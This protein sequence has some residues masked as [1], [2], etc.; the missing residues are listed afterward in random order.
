MIT[1]RQIERYWMAK[2]Y[3]RLYREL[4]AARP[5]AGFRLEVDVRAPLAAAM[6]IIRLDELAQ[7]HVPLYSRLLR[8]ILTSQEA[9]GGWGA[10]VTTALCVRALLCGS[11]NGYAVDLGIEYLANLQKTEGI[12]PN[13]PLRRM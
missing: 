7:S 1:V 4:V 6:A 3:P 5:E 10:P 2:D 13:L 11:G 8:S 9:D 12:W